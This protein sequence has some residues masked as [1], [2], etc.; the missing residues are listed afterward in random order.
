M[1]T[2]SL[3]SD[4]PAVAPRTA[5][6]R[7]GPHPSRP[8]RRGAPAR[9]APAPELERPRAPAP[10]DRTL[11]DVISGA[12]EDLSAHRTTTCP[13]CAGGMTPRYGSGPAVVAATCGSCGTSLR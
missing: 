5:R 10:E 2:L 1:T 11:E 4:V 3:F 6:E 9:P 13:V 8:V 7:R 12:W